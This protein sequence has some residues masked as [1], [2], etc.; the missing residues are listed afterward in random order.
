M[1]KFELSCNITANPFYNVTWTKGD[2]WLAHITYMVE[3]RPKIKIN[4]N[5]AMIYDCIF[6]LKP[7]N[8]YEHTHTTFMSSR[9]TEQSVFGEYKCIT[10]NEYG[11]D[12]QIFNIIEKVG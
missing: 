6:D 3:K 1:D 4:T 2:K 8:Q 7:V 11:T 10:S 12:E 5:V 9:L